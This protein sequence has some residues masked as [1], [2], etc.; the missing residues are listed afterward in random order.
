MA[1]ITNANLFLKELDN[2]KV[3]LESYMDMLNSKQ[4]IE[5]KFS[6]ADK[7]GNLY[8]FEDGYKIQLD[9]DQVSGKRYDPYYRNRYLKNSYSVVVK[10]VDAEKKI[11][12]VS[13]VDAKELTKDELIKEIEESIER[14]E[15]CEMT[16]RLTSIA[17]DRNRSYALV[18][19]GGVGIL[20]VIKLKDWSPVYTSDLRRVAAR[21][22]VFRVVVKE[23][24]YWNGKKGYACSRAEALGFDPWEKIEEK[25]PEQT[26]VNVTC[27]EV[28]PKN[29]F[30]KIDGIAEINAYCE[31]PASE[32]N[33][34]V[35]VGEKY[36]GYVAKVNE[37]TKLLRVRIFKRL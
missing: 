37:K 30:G 26:I 8:I 35:V 28:T 2:E 9:N 32:K 6:M 20:G 27:E 13:Q 18:D 24:I 10:S 4:V 7:D 29:F 34:K 36:Q 5:K 16:V 21:G 1:E 14:N 15:K 3:I 31:F 25:L 11:I 17:G 22:D 12:H 33:I 19:I 23:H